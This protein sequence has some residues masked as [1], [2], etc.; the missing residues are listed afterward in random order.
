MVFESCVDF[1]F[2]G[3]KA[4]W[5]DGG[6]RILLGDNTDGGAV[7]MWFGGISARPQCVYIHI[8]LIIRIFNSAL[9]K[10][11]LTPHVSEGNTNIL[12]V[13]YKHS[14]VYNI[15]IMTSEFN[16]WP[17]ASP[18]TIRYNLFVLRDCECFSDIWQT[19]L[20]QNIYRSQGICL[21][22]TTKTKYPGLC[23]KWYSN[24]RSQSFLNI[25]NLHIQSICKKNNLQSSL[26]HVSAVDRLLQGETSKT[27]NLTYSI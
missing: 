26:L 2:A 4:L 25:N 6:G 7:M 11:R 23:Y 3:R 12:T 10:M 14:H 17:A 24:P 16:L 27:L 20:G 9:G 13:L 8:Q 21:H 19:L 22:R 15:N 1:C 18:R 5:D